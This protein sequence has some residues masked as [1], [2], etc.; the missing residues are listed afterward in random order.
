MKEISLKEISS[1]N[2]M[3][4]DCGEEQ[5]NNYLKYYAKQNEDKGLGRTFVL[6]EKEEIYGFYT[7]SS[8]SIKFE[9]LPDDLKKKLPHYPIPCVRIARLGVSLS[10]QKQGIGAILLKNAF[11]RIVTVFI[12][13]GISFIIVDAKPSSK[14]FY[15]HYGFTCI[16]EKRNLYAISIFT[17]IKAMLGWLLITFRYIRAIIIKRKVGSFM[18][19]YEIKKFPLVATILTVIGLVCAVVAIASSLLSDGFSWI[20]S[21]ALIEIIATVLFLAGLTIGR[22]GLLRVISII[23]TVCLLVTN[24][25]LSIVEYN[26]KEV[27]LFSVALLMLVAS[28]LEL[29]YFVAIRNQKIRKMYIVAS[30]V[31][32][33]LVAIFSIYFLINNIQNTPEGGKV[34]YQ[35]FILLLS[36]TF[37]TLLPVFVH[38]SMN[39]VEA[40][41]KPVEEPIENPEQ[42][43]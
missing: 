20:A 2:L 36:Y 39:M 12:N 25:V 40:E 43:Q 42:K 14:G 7:L 35:T 38:K 24:F 41:N 1:S 4:F 9:E 10:R 17:I 37:I 27:V 19:K 11:K 34:Q 8:A 3:S 16:D 21:L 23:V 22:V 6:I 15:E 13:I 26:K 31:L 28:V 30:F 18:I 29:V 33:A 5:L 32:G